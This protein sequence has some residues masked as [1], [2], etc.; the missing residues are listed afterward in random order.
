MKIKPVVFLLVLVCLFNPVFGEGIDRLAGRIADAVAES[1]KGAHQKQVSVIRFENF[2]DLTDQA[3]VKFYQLL[4]AKLEGHPDFQFADLMIN[5]H[6]GNGVFNEAA[7]G[8]VQFPV[9][10][11]LVRNVDKIGA[12]AVV[13]S[14]IEDKII[15]LK[16]AE[17]FVSKGESDILDTRSYGFREMGFTKMT[18]IDVESQLLDFK[19]VKDL[20]GDERYYF[21]YPDKIDVFGTI[22][23]RLTKL[24]SVDLD[25]GRPYYPAI[26]PEGKLF[27]TFHQNKGYIAA[28]TNFS[29]HAKMFALEEL[30]LQELGELDFVPVRLAAI[31]QQVFLLGVR[32]EMGKNYFQG[33]IVVAPFSDGQILSQQQYEK[34]VPPHYA[35]DFSVADNQLNSIHIVDRDYNYQFLGPDFE[36]ATTGISRRGSAIAA[37][38]DEWVAVSDFTEAADQDRLYFYKV[39][40]TA[41]QFV[42]Q[43]SIEGSIIAIGSGIWKTGE[44]FWVFLKKPT[45]Y[46]PKY[47]LQFWKKN[48]PA[49]QLPSNAPE[50]GDQ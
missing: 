39:D 12:G 48:E 17:E 24:L 2:S 34:Q 8:N 23:N 18:E 37:L 21:L 31:N 5:F 19:T 14:R 45:R 28:G 40:K 33:K 26:V 35:I 43:K 32:Y 1:L 3:A 10:L 46:K 15:G 4:V 27:V 49:P 44:G 47:K 29:P 30:Q 36:P 20:Q 9:Y 50:G 7:A 11:K 6:N 38:N 41:R 16:Y 42:Y 22:Q 25:W 13:F